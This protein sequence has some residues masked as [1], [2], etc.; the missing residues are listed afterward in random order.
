MRE[1]GRAQPRLLACVIC[2]AAGLSPSISTAAVGRT[3]TSVDVSSTGEAIYSIPIAAPP[4]ARGMTPQLALV[5]S[6]RSGSTLLGAGWSIAGLSAITRCP[7]TWA[8]DGEVRAIRNDSSD[9]FCLNGNKLRLT[10]GTYGQAGATYQTEIETFSR[11]T[12]YGAAGNGPAYFVIEGKDGLYYEYG[13]TGDSRIESVGQSTARAWAVNRIR[14]RSGNVMD[15]IYDE[16]TTNGAY[17]ILRVEYTSNSAQGLS[18]QYQIDFA[19]QTKPSNEIDTGYLAG[20]VIKEITRLDYV[21][22]KHNSTLVRRYDLA[23]ESALSSTSKSRLQSVQECAGASLDCLPATTFTYQNGANGL[24]GEVSMGINM[25]TTPWPMDVN[26]DGRDDLVYSS[27]TT[28]G[29]GNWMVLLANSAGGYDAPRDTGVT[30]TNYHRA[31]PI[32]YN[33]DGREDLLV[34]YSGGTWWVMLGHATGL[35][36]PSN[37]YA[38]AGGGGSD[39]RAFDVNGDGLD[40]LIWDERVG[41]AGGD[42]I[43]YRLRDWTNGGFSS[44]VYYLAGPMSADTRIESGPFGASGQTGSQRNPDFNGDGRG[45]LVYRLTRRRFNEGSGQY[46]FFRS[47]VVVC[48]GAWSASLTNPNASGV[49]FFG[50]ANGDGK[51]DLF[52]LNQLGSLAVRF[53]TGTGLTPELAVGGG[54]AGWAILDWDGDGYDDVLLSSSGAWHLRRS[55]GE[56]FAAAVNTGMAAGAR[57]AVSDINGDGLHDLSQLVGTDWRYRTH[58]GVYPDLLQTA[59]DGYGNDL[60]F[61]YAP[62][63]SAS[64]NYTKYAD[65]SFPE[66]DYQGSMYVVN[67]YSAPNGIGGTYTS[68]YHYYGARMHLQGRG[69]EGFYARRV[70]D[71]RN[72]LYKYDYFQRLFPYTGALF[73]SDVYQPNGSTLMSRMQADWTSHPYD[74]PYGS[75]A[76]TRFLPYVSTSTISRYEVGGPY[77]G[78]M[79][80]ATTT[81]NSVYSATG[82]VYDSTTTTRETSSANGVQSQ[83]AYVQRVHQPTADLLN[84]TA[85]WCIGRPGRIEATNSHDQYGGA[86][87]TRT[88]TINWN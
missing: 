16:D 84:D 36:A 31:T 85:E 65:A 12:S 83:A 77:N 48:P 11:A 52:Y 27:S 76:E 58:A 88:T 61:S 40:D 32:D 41:Y 3:P 35:G 86:P 78:A 71:N 7:R 25:L 1:F 57:V 5:Y 29:G 62:L 38:P 64:A 21:D 22:I 53:S 42:A 15:F 2:I 24:N 79:I 33:A 67:N 19:W 26:G 51:S 81:N 55:T 49:P 4:G 14:D 73:Q 60:T 28:S 80:S 75:G 50:D 68:S 74:H 56:S 66:Q 20:S 63:T 45:D 23:Y 82:V 44:T 69:L 18:S 34:S 87:I 8:S 70:H 13:A 9:R 17:R 72:N 47:L 43:R 6:H 37:T 59:T 46:T 54:S 30:N 10:A 39:A